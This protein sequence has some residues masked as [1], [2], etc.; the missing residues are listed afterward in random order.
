MTMNEIVRY[1]MGLDYKRNMTI[2]GDCYIA[3]YYFNIAGIHMVV[4][5][6]FG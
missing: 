4:F 5:F 1:S 6:N 2:V 3:F